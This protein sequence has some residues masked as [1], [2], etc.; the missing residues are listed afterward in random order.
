M[1]SLVRTLFGSRSKPFLILGAPVIRISDK[2]KKFRRA[3][4]VRTNQS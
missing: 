3:P 1:M 4:G 2:A